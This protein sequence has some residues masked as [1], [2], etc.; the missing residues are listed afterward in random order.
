MI[1]EFQLMNHDLSK[2]IRIKE[3]KEEVKG[4]KSFVFEE[5]NNISYKAGQ[6]LTLLQ[7]SPD[8]VEVRRS[9]SITSSPVLNE[10]LSIGVKRIENGFFSRQLIDV[11]KAG[12]KLQTTG[13]GGLFILPD[14]IQNF[15][16]VFFFAAGS[17][18]TPIY[19]LVKT[20]L[21]AHPHLLLVL[22]YSNASADKTVFLQP[23]QELQKLFPSRFHLKILFSDTAD[24][25]KARLHREL[26]L[27][28]FNQLSIRNRD[29]ILFYI[30][31]PE[32]YMRLCT[33]TLQENG[34][35]PDNIKKENFII[36]SV[37]KRDALPPDKENHIATIR[38]GNRHHKISVCYPDSILK[39]AKKQS[40]DLPYS[41]EAGICG[42]CVAKC[43]TGTVWHSY[44]EVLTEKELQKG[45]VLTCVGH[46]VDGDV[47]LEIY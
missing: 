8:G 41:C 28:F 40:I 39:A 5:N 27:E 15:E 26:I 36:H 34:I 2:A 16:Q 23:L 11:A 12:D 31:G 18:I 19:S 22:I 7:T 38:I 25:L 4:F 9:Y 44:N 17:G 10:P 14:D 37:A 24:L 42:N 43:T 30:C 20:A 46:P 21:Y 32:T 47:A 35:H 6:Y 33:Y 29:G 1:P 13:S 45:L 3:I